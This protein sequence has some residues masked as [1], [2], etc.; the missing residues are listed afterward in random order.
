MDYRRRCGGK[1]TYGFLQSV[2]RRRMQSIKKD[3][4]GIPLFR[5][6]SDWF[7]AHGDRRS[8]IYTYI[9]FA[10][11]PILG[12]VM[13][14]AV[15]VGGI[16][17]ILE[18]LKGMMPLSRDR[19]MRYATVPIYL[20][21]ASYLVALAV[22]PMPDWEV[23]APVLPLLLFPFLYSS[24][25]LSKKETIARS[26]VS[27]S[28]IACYGALVLAIIQFHGF[29]MRAE[30]SAGNAIVFATV[31]AIAATV[32]LAG[33][34]IREGRA[35]VPLF[36]AFC[37]GSI[38]VLYS[39][40]RTTWLA[41]FLSTAAV[42]WI[43]RERRHAWGSAVAVSCAALAV[44]VIAFA[45]AQVIPSRVEALVRDWQQISDHGD[46]NSSLGRRA[47]LWEIGLA[48]VREKPILGHGPQS[49]KPLIRDGFQKIGLPVFYSHLHNGF[50]NAWVEAGIVGMLSLVA[51]FVVAAWLAIRTL[52]TTAAAEAR[53]GAVMLIAL[54]TTYVVNGQVGIL[55]GHDI[56]DAML[57]ATLAVGIYLAAGT[58]MLKEDVTYA[59]RFPWRSG[60]RR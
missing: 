41:L 28:M 37:A 17:G 20:Y 53:L 5:W 23:A 40:S 9:C 54:V 29:G 16:G 12:S 18:I 39:G 47:E 60:S 15:I 38:A 8:E 24:W 42:L 51:I 32:S 36:G 2:G 14:I 34:F 46:Y 56:L 11:A 13:T 3:K 25:C 45:G 30:G 59:W 35:A 4:K 10:S 33:A 43:Y 1:E 57:I 21:C 22:N 19:F 7:V 27:A 50:L 49:T 48:A 58:S 26:V 52:V 44:G 31:T 6:F 55:I